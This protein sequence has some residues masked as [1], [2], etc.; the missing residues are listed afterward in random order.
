MLFKLLGFLARMTGSGTYENE[1]EH[2]SEHDTRD[3]VHN[4]YLMRA[5][6]RDVQANWGFAATAS[7]GTA[8]LSILGASPLEG[9]LESAVVATSSAST[10]VSASYWKRVRDESNFIGRL[11]DHLEHYPIY[12]RAHVDEP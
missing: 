11:I 5:H 6:T 8:A 9:W 3:L 7:L 12:T 2:I 1:Q 10:L 4:L